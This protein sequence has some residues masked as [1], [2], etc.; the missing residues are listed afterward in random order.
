MR[1]FIM[2]AAREEM[3]NRDGLFEPSNNKIP[4]LG[5]GLYGQSPCLLYL[6]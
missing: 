5:R 2:A 3:A 4:E 1:N 6:A